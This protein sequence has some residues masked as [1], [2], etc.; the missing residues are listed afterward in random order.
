M[1]SAGYLLDMR[2][3]TLWNISAKALQVFNSEDARISISAA[4][5]ISSNMALSI[6]LSWLFFIYS[7]GLILP[8]KLSVLPEVLQLVSVVN[9]GSGSGIDHRFHALEIAVIAAPRQAQGEAR[10][11]ARNRD[12]LVGEI[13]DKAQ[14]AAANSQHGALRL[15]AMHPTAR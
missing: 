13:I 4:C 7:F 15:M 6:L 11:R 12:R 3:G 2:F 10:G 5:I 9:P 14:R 1:L 8:K